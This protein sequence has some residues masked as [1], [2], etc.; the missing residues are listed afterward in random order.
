MDFT[1]AAGHP[2][3]FCDPAALADQVLQEAPGFLVVADRYGLAEGHLLL[4]PRAHYPCF[5]SLPPDLLRV[6]RGLQ[7]KIENFLVSRFQR[8][9]YFEHGI[10]GQTV[11]H[12]H[13]HA[14]PGAVSILDTLAHGRY[15]AT[16]QSWEEVQ[17]FYHALQGYLYFEQ[18]GQAW[19]FSPE[20]V[21]PGYFQALVA[22]AL[23]VPDRESW[24]GSAVA[25]AE[26]LRRLWRAHWANQAP[27]NVPER[28]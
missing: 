14:V 4:M 18:Q 17:R 8:P 24:G 11:P 25:P 26:R 16:V 5:G 22:A 2:C 13:L 28:R 3:A 19:V 23:G 21:P 1:P 12:A 10:A 20:R 7:G 9:F 27:G 15:A 6:A